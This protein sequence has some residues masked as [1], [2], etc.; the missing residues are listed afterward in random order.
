MFVNWII[1]L[2][3]P[4]QRHRPPGSIWNRACCSPQGPHD[5]PALVD[6]WAMGLTHAWPVS[7]VFRPYP[8]KYPRQV[9]II[10]ELPKTVTGKILRREL[11][12]QARQETG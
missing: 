7:A 2:T 10:A 6:L 8:S 11:R 9:E 5:P 3:P 1:N 4:D 12:A